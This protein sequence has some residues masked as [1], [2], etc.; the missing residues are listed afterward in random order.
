MFD[1]SCTACGV[2]LGDIHYVCSV[3]DQWFCGSCM[4]TLNGLPSSGPDDLVWCLGCG[5]KLA[6]SIADEVGQQ[7]CAFEELG[8][9]IEWKRRLYLCDVIT[10]VLQENGYV[11]PSSE[12]LER[13]VD[14]CLL[15]LR[16]E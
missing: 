13:A 4:T 11:V 10:R 2:F 6:Q 7:E 12:W 3:C 15:Y 9:A 1:W 5:E 8:R 16:G 14:A